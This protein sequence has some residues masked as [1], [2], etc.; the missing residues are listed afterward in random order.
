M[1]GRLG[2]VDAKS[3][4]VVRVWVREEVLG[5]LEEW[6]EKELEVAEEKALEGSQYFEIYAE[7]L[8]DVLSKIQ[9]IRG[10]A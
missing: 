6:L 5:E 2:F 10:E 8:R 7:A 1:Q 4:E 3:L 9:E